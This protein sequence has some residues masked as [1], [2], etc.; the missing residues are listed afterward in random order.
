MSILGAQALPP[1]SAALFLPLVVLP[2]ILFGLRRAGVFRRDSISGPER[3]APGE[4]LLTLTGIVLA[5]YFAGFLLLLAVRP[6]VRL[7]EAQLLIG[8]NA[9][10]TAA[11]FAA[12]VVLT[13]TLRPNGL[14]LLGLLPSGLG[15]GFLTAVLTSF[16]LIPLVYL[17]SILVTVL[18]HLLGLK[19]PEPHVILKELQETQNAPLILLMA[20][21]ATI[22]A[23][24]AE[25]VTFRGY[26]Q[27]LIARVITLAR[28]RPTPPPLPTVADATGRADAAA[29]VASGP[30]AGGPTSA[31]LVTPA[32]A[33]TPEGVRVLPYQSP[34]PFTPTGYRW[35]A[36]LITAV[37]FAAVHGEPAFMPPLFVLAVGLGYAYERTG[38]LWVPIFTHALFNS[39]QIVVFLT[40]VA[41][42]AGAPA[43]T[44]PTN[45]IP[46]TTQLL[47]PPAF[48]AL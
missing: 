26:L 10:F 7:P 21:L 20:L 8:L 25:E 44:P 23:P 41:K 15:R 46:P 1:E 36:V 43:P 32:T 11:V 4:S 24:L 16:L 14:R 5:A 47:P 45:P 19:E 6:L 39:L 31:D 22:L 38:N 12:L 33:P 27:T 37:L 17:T 40:A 28:R 3:I 29:P 13:A 35:A 48:T 18:I 42:P 34:A 30:V 9:V 2:L